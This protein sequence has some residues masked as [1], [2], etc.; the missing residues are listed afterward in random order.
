[1]HKSPVKD[2][3]TNCNWYLKESKVVAPLKAQLAIICNCGQS[4]N[5]DSWRDVFITGFLPSIFNRRFVNKTCLLKLD[6]TCSGGIKKG[7]FVDVQGGSSKL[8]LGL[9][10]GA[11]FDVKTEQ[12]SSQYKRVKLPR[13]QKPWQIWSSLSKE[14]WYIFFLNE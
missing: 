8:W 12:A 10:L 9:R 13:S 2:A 4:R 6:L 3:D 1:M 5:V 7:Y 11:K 14:W